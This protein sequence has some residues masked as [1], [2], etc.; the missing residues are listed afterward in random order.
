MTIPDTTPKPRKDHPMRTKP[1][2]PAHATNTPAPGK[3]LTS[4]EAKG[5]TPRAP[6]PRSVSK[7]PARP[8]VKRHE[9]FDQAAHSPARPAREAKTPGVRQPRKG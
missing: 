1:S 4:A 8:P 5:S 7:G 9:P 2:R 6:T 3:S